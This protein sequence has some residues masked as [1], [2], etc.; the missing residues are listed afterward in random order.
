MRP[1]QIGIALFICA[2]TAAAG[3]SQALAQHYPDYWFLHSSL[4][5]STIEFVDA[6]SIALV[7]RDVKQAWIWVFRSRET[8]DPAVR[9][10]D[11]AEVNCRT[12]QRH[13]LKMTVYNAQGGYDKARSGQVAS[14]W[15]YV[16]PGTPG[17]IELKFICSGAPARAS[18]GVQ[19]GQG[20]MLEEAA[21]RT[22][23]LLQLQALP[24]AVKPL[25]SR[26][27]MML[28]TRCLAA[29]MPLNALAASRARRLCGS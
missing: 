10:A 9:E 16:T 1:R 5:N 26:A 13:A 2:G 21:Q 19:L 11:L 29:F 27:Q 14:P 8:G 25:D 3:S 17:E 28:R 4:D 6:A 24:G 7:N 23:D 18:I 20:I 12:H 22:L 15:D